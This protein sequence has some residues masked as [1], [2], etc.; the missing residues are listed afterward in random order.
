MKRKGMVSDIA[1][2][3]SLRKQHLVHAKL[4]LDLSPIDSFYW[5]DFPLDVLIRFDALPPSVQE[6]KSAKP[7]G[8]DRRRTWKCVLREFAEPTARMWRSPKW[9]SAHLTS[10]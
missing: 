2:G 10:C 5:D 1:V 6:A 4:K 7:K 9:G 8:A 3:P